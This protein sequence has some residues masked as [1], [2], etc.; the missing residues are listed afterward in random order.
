MRIVESNVC[1]IAW[2]I[3][4]N[5]T[6]YVYTGGYGGGFFKGMATS[7]HGIHTMK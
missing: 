7:P 6:A 3:G 4:H 2:G 1:G 5:G